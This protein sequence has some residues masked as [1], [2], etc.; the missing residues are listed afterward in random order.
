M[1][2]ILTIQDKYNENKTYEVQYTKRRYVVQ[3]F[4]KGQKVSEK[5]RLSISRI[6][7]MLGLTERSIRKALR[8]HT[9]T[10]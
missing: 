1:M 4:V 6:A 9:I 3:Q 2:M 5:I 8:N 7:E 10:R